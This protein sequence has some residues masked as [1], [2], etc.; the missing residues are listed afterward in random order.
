MNH[1][2]NMN[3]RYSESSQENLFDKQSWGPKLWEVTHT[4]SRISYN[5]FQYS[6]TI[7]NEFLLIYRLSYPLFS[8][9]STLFRIY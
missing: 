4:F 2:F 1:T 8:L 3:N 6:K 5:P 9:F 7:R